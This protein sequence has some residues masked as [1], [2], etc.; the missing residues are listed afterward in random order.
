MYFPIVAPE[1]VLGFFQR[2]PT[3]EYTIPVDK[4]KHGR[5]KNPRCSPDGKRAAGT[6]KVNLRRGTN[7]FEHRADLGVI[8]AITRPHHRLR[9]AC[10]EQT[11][12]QEFLPNMDTHDLAQREPVV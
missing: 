10:I 9:R 3:F 1:Q 6:K 4:F 5:S 7:H 11:V 12:L 2:I 8:P